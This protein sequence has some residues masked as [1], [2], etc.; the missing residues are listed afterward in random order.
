MFVCLTRVRAHKK[1]IPPTK[2][3]YIF[4][5]C[6]FEIFPTYCFFS[7][8]RILIIT[9]SL[10]HYGDVEES[11]FKLRQF[12]P[13]FSKCFLGLVSHCVIITQINQIIKGPNTISYQRISTCQLRRF[14]YTTRSCNYEYLTFD[15]QQLPN[16]QEHFISLD[17]KITIGIKKIT[18]FTKMAH[19]LFQKSLSQLLNET[20]CF[21]RKC[22]V[23][24]KIHFSSLV[25]V[26]GEKILD[27]FRLE[28]LHVALKANSD[29]NSE[30]VTALIINISS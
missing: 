11:K 27:S 14:E 6:H 7:K 28:R 16:I 18:T 1:K 24:S 30:V 13:S 29:V 2:L 3:R 23:R 20:S 8:M 15:S 17:Q 22:I 9:L 4:Q 21:A 10:L 25:T 26:E 12:D 19:I 5:N